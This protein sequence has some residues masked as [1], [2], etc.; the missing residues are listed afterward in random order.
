MD[1][2]KSSGIGDKILED[3]RLDLQYLDQELKGLAA[4]K[5]QAGTPNPIY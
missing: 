5:D 3:F 4:E 1:Y 2:L